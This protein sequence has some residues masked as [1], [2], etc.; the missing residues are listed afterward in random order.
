MLDEASQQFRQ[1]LRNFSNNQLNNV[2]K[3]IN[4][5]ITGLSKVDKNVEVSLFI[6]YH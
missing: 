2:N 3:E 1:E 4:Q 6:H 5:I